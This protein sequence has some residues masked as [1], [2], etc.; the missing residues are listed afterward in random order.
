M[1]RGK[2]ENRERARQIRDFSGLRW[3]NI[4]PT[5][6]DSLVDFQNDIFIFTEY[7]VKGNELPF[8]QRLAIER[9]VDA[10]ANSGKY[11]LGLIAEHETPIN[12]DINC[13]KALVTEYR[14]G[15]RKEWAVP[16]ESRSV[17]ETID[18]VLE[19]YKPDYLE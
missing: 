3:K 9:V 15:S 1:E 7:K 11:C 4:T 5:D 19:R 17:K 14:I 2:I 12:E 10:I 18:M 16:K 6:I 13:A 8:G